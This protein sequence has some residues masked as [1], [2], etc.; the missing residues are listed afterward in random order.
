MR[1]APEIFAATAARVVR[2]DGLAEVAPL[3]SPAAA[4]ILPKRFGG[5][6]TDDSA[7]RM[8][9]SNASSGGGLA[10][11]VGSGGVLRNRVGGQGLLQAVA[12]A[13]KAR[14]D[15]ADGRL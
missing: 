1:A 3:S 2:H 11:E 13:G 12:S 15:R 14:P 10:G 6:S 4:M 9:R 7:C 5:G 8:D